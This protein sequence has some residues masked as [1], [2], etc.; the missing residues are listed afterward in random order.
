MGGSTFR[1]PYEILEMIIAQL[2]CDLG[3]L[4]ACSLTCR[5]WYIVAVPHLHHTLT[6]GDYERG[7][8][9]SR[10]SPLSKLHELGLIPLVKE[11]RV[12]Q[13]VGVGSGWFLPQVFSH[14]DLGY[15]S[16]FSNIQTLVLQWLRLD[17]FILDIEHYFGSFSPLL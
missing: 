13:R 7:T 16:T 2:T 6:L 17:R 12:R 4:K 8:T 3:A 1:L 11:I 10:L 15:F 9:Y 14:C 5:S